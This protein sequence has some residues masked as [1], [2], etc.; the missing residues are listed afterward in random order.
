MSEDDG[1]GEEST[2][3]GDKQQLLNVSGAG[4]PRNRA[5]V[6][7]IAGPNVGEMFK[8]DGVSDIGR[9]QTVKIRLT[10]TEISRQHARL[11]V[12]GDRVFVEDLDS[13][14]GT[15]VNGAQIKRQ[16]L[17]DGDK[18]PFPESIARPGVEPIDSAATLN[19]IDD[20]DRSTN[21]FE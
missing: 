13:T 15:F 21:W 2:V 16:A 11:V 4:R 20:A 5:Y 19:A 8:V 14:N 17:K 12:E 9:G 6:I 18:I 7:V 1:W 3:V 10:D